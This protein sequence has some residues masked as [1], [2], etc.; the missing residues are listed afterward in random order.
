MA[1]K[2]VPPEVQSAID[3]AKAAG[4]ETSIRNGKI[5]ISAPD[6]VGIT[7]GFYPNDESI[8]KFR[9]DAEKYN[10]I[11][12]PARTPEEQAAIIANLEKEQAEKDAKAN[13]K[14]KAYEAEQARKAAEAEAA[15]Q[16]AEEATKAGMVEEPA[17]EPEKKPVVR[18]IPKGMPE[19]DSSLLGQT[20]SKL[21]LILNPAG[22][23]EYYCIECWEHGAKFTSKRPQGLAMHRGVRHGAY[24]NEEAAETQENA[25]VTGLPTDVHDALELLTTVVQDA[26]TGAAPST[27]HEELKKQYAV[28]QAEL[29][30][31]RKQF[32]R[33]L[34]ASDNQYTEAKAAFDKVREADKAKIHELTQDLNGKDKKHETEVTQLTKAFRTLLEQVRHALNNEAPL[35]AI[36]TID[37]LIKPYLQG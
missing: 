28:L 16:K 36:G 5:V 30:E 11:E 23:Q 10:L 29:E 27:E 22:V 12:G 8:K 17:P 13:E 37:E 31:A 21:F 34:A 35:K 33:D 14:R 4:W 15:R 18:E 2:R 6:G 24:R 1:N 25:A 20:D 3:N 26:L 32:A 9:R 19:F 7:M